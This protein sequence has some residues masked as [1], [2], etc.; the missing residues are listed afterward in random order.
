LVADRVHKAAGVELERCDPA[1]LRANALELRVGRQHPALLELGKK[2]QI[3][4]GA[5]GELLTG[6]ALRV[7]LRRQVVREDRFHSHRLASM[8]TAT[9]ARGA[10]AA[11]GARAGR[12][13][14]A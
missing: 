10:S 13:R 3:D 4:L 11:S 2:T 6:E 7:A 12:P 8:T 14:G 9:R 5:P 1:E